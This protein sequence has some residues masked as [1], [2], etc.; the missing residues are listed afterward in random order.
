MLGI[1]LALSMFGR[2]VL[3]FILSRVGG[4]GRVPIN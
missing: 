4:L 3:V 2:I 1:E